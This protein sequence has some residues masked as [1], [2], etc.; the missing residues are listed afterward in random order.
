MRLLLDTHSFLWFIEGNERLSIRARESILDM[1][2]ERL[3]ST[4]TLWEIAI[5][6]S[7]GKLNLA[8]PFDEVIVGHVIRNAMQPL[9]IEPRHL[10]RLHTLPFHHRDPFDRLLAA[11][12]LS[13]SLRLVSCD[14]VF[15]GYSVERLW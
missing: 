8:F 3:V 10:A 2:N 4:A 11:Q 7:L 13:D 1:E 6:S 5:K 14:A 9:H 12:A 15:D